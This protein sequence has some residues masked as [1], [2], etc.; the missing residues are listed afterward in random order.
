MKDGWLVCRRAE[1]SLV[2]FY[3]GP[4]KRKAREKASKLLA[5]GTGEEVFV[6]RVRGT[7][8]LTVD[9][10]LSTLPRSAF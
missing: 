6:A 5:D 9:S 4:D 10:M 3:N 8:R 2:V 1:E 7:V